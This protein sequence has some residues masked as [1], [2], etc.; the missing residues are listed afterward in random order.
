MDPIKTRAALIGATVL[1]AGG[2]LYAWRSGLLDAPAPPPAAP[3]TAQGP[4]EERIEHPVATV[5]EQ[6]LPPLADSDAPLAGELAA[7]WGRPSLPELLFP[8][9]LARRF[10]ATVDNLGRE[11]VPLEVRAARAVPGPLVVSGGDEAPVLANANAARYEPYVS[12][13]ESVDVEQAATLYERWYPRLQES[14]EALGYPGK[15]F[16][17]RFVA[18]LDDLLATPELR[19]P[20]KLVRPNVLYRYADPTLERRSA[21]QKLLLRMGAENAARVKARL[22]LL[23]D[24]LARPPAEPQSKASP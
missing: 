17:D 18:V 7:L 8:D 10:V 4:L 19:G 12:L 5:A 13:L 14:Y 1:L 9:R 24:R 15:Y 6:P 2:A 22:K 16:N 3:A 21:G 11:Q 20:V 23:R